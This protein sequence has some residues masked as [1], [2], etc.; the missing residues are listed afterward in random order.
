MKKTASGK[1]AKGNKSGTPKKAAG[2]KK[3]LPAFLKKKLGKKK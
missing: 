2:T 3:A 1:F